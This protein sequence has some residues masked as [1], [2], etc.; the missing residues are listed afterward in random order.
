MKTFVTRDNGRAERPGLA[1]TPE[2]TPVFS[3]CSALHA[4]RVHRHASRAGPSKFA[5]YLRSAAQSSVQSQSQS[6]FK[7]KKKVAA[8]TLVLSLRPRLPLLG[9][10]G[11]EVW[12]VFCF[13]VRKGMPFACC[14]SLILLYFLCNNVL[15]VRSPARV[16]R[17]LRKTASALCE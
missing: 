11:R 13:V 15:A 2:F 5:L 14:V 6:Q 3:L 9:E 1:Q 12:W 8:I 7:K 16:R 4:F 10:P 17:A